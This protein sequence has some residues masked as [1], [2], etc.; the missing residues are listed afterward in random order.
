VSAAVKRHPEP[1]PTPFASAERAALAHAIA[2]AKDR[3]ARRAEIE[4]AFQS[5][6]TAAWA[7]TN[8]VDAA[9]EAEAGKA[10]MYRRS[11]DPDVVTD[12]AKRDVEL[13]RAA[14]Q[15]QKS[16]L[17]AEKDLYDPSTSNIAAAALA[18]V[19][20]E[21]AGPAVALAARL[22]RMER[23]M[24]EVGSVVSWLVGRGVISDDASRRFEGVAPGGWGSRIGYCPPFA[25]FPLSTG[26]QALEAA[27]E[28]LARDASAPLPK[29]DAAGDDEFAVMFQKNR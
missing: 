14:L 28:A 2:A 3:A 21:Q 4:Q 29:M 23:E 10:R 5:A 8:V 16:E 1:T 26:A 9:V 11:P 18:V 24:F 6:R 7:A 20:A 13:T 27:F 19:R 25:T 12:A 22:E 17:D 15:A